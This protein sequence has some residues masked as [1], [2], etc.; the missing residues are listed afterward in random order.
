MRNATHVEACMDIPAPPVSN[1][2]DLDEQRANTEHWQTQTRRLCLVTLLAKTS[3]AP[4]G[5]A[6]A[7]TRFNP[8]SSANILNNKCWKGTVFMMTRCNM[9]GIVQKDAEKRLLHGI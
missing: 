6:D 4:R 9:Q 1:A 8:N 3:R 2:N 7:E 5:R